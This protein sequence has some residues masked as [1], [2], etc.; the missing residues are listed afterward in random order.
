MAMPGVGTGLTI[1]VKFMSMRCTRKDAVI[2]R[3]MAAAVTIGAVCRCT[4]LGAMPSALIDILE[5]GY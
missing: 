5:A 4:A 3:A 2:Y 1:A